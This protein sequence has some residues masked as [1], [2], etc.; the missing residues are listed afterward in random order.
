[1]AYLL[2]PSAVS[3]ARS[4]AG[5]WRQ[6]RGRCSSRPA[7]RGGRDPAG[8]RWRSTSPVNV[9]GSA[10]LRALPGLGAAPD[11]LL[12]LLG[13][14]FCGTLT[15]FPTLGAD[16]VR[17]LEKRALGRALG[18]AGATVVLGLGAAAAGYSAA[19]AISAPIRTFL[20]RWFDTYRTAV[21]RMSQ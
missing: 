10:L 14:G 2:A 17:L 15:T 13:T 11:W 1:M 7:A 18:Y 21:A 16:V 12:V 5:R 19:A 6:R 20:L 4:P 3:W 9:A 8:G